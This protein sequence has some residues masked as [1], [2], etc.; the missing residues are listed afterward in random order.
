[1]WGCFAGLVARLGV[2]L[3]TSSVA[4]EPSAVTPN[5]NAVVPSLNSVIPSLNSVIPS[6]NSV[7]PSVAEGSQP[8]G[9]GPSVGRRP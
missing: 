8:A 2:I 6:L 4:Q 1:M 5:P 9:R 3:M 7:I